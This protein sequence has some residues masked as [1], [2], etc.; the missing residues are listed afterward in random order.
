[1]VLRVPLG[2]FDAV[3]GYLVR[4]TADGQSV[5]CL[6]GVMNAVRHIGSRIITPL[7]GVRITGRKNG[8][9]ALGAFVSS[10]RK[11]IDRGGPA[12]QAIPVSARS[13]DVTAMQKTRLRSGTTSMR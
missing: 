1:M 13:V 9:G 8:E 4:V 5:P 2:P 12:R 7:G 6:R 3:D 11:G 10:R